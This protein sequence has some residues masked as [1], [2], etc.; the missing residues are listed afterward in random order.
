MIIARIA[1]KDLEQN[2][3][4]S[5]T[6]ALK[7]LEPLN[8]FTGADEFSFVDASAFINAQEDA[9]FT[10][11]SEWGYEYTPFFDELEEIEV[12]S[13]NK[14]NLL[15]TT[16]MSQATVDAS[17][18][19][20]IDKTFGKSL[21]LRY[22][23]NQVG[24][25]HQPSRNINRFSSSYP[26]GNNFGKD[27]KISIEGYKNV[28]DLFEDAIGQYPKFNYPLTK[29][30]ELNTY[31]DQIMTEFPKSNFKSQVADT[32]KSNWSKES[33]EIAKSMIYSSTL[34]SHNVGDVDELKAAVNK[35]LALAGYR[36]SILVQY[37][38]SM[39]KDGY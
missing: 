15:Q 7:M 13:H 30:N 27:Q 1:E 39:Q 2:A 25:I 29:T 33:F 3:K 6:Q 36:L 23:M 16:G 17:S 9:G 26:K 18:G 35:Q 24:K 28:F 38:M 8:E 5:L 10:L 34:S 11:T 4:A 14:F 37:M 32:T 22:V 12:E 20:R 19:S 21:N 31:V